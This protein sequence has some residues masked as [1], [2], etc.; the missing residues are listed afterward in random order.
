MDERL[1]NLS[2]R[3]FVARLA[4][5][6]P[7]PGGGSAAA[8]AGAMAAALMHMVIELTAGRPAAQDHETALADLKLAAAAAQSE[9]LALTETDAA[10]YEAVVRARRLPRDTDRDREAR[11]VQI[12][13]ATRDATRVPLDAARQAAR[14]LDIAAAL[15]PI[16]NRNAIS[17]VGVGALLAAAAVRGAAHN[18]LINI[19][20]LPDD[21]PLRTDAPAAVRELL[22]A[23]PARESAIAAAVEERMG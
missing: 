5:N 12:H 21:D 4:T 3:E 14:I 7:V 23:L 10:A 22:D 6:S 16:G 1:T 8:L 2:V 15:V 18:V 17:D 19:P 20:F 9:L 13:A 11:Q